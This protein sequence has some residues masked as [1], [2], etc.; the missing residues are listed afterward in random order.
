ML[1]VFISGDFV[2]ILPTMS[3]GP[4]KGF[5]HVTVPDTEG[6]Q[7]ACLLGVPVEPRNRQCV[8]PGRIGGE[9]SIGKRSITQTV[10]D[11]FRPNSR[12]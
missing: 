5:D 9:P 4:D 10:A 7:L 8:H 2:D 12:I 3:A 6:K 11:Y 1:V